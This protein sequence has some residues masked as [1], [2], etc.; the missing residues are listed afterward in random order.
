MENHMSP[1]RVIFSTGSLYTLD[2]AYVFDLAAKAGFD[3]IEVMC[4]DRFSSRDPDYLRGAS[5]R[6]GLPVLVVHTPF[7]FNLIGWLGEGKT[8]VGRIRQTLKIAENLKAESIVVHLPRYV[9]QGML[10]FGNR[11]FPFPW[12]NPTYAIKAWIENEL[13]EIQAQTSVK[14]GIENMPLWKL[15]RFNV[16]FS[17]WNEVE[18]WSRVHDYLTLDTTHW[19]TKGV[20]PI[21]AYNAA[22]GRVCNIH[23]SN[24]EKGQEHRLPQKGEL[25]LAA[26]L[27]RLTETHYEGTVSVEVA[28]DA[29]E[30]YSANS[31]RKN[32]KTTLAFCREHL[33][34]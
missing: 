11:R 10:N 23:L 7:T 15:G 16:D 22:M 2:V 28:L 12:T 8:Q 19:A 21:E 31:L 24:Y 26:F 18:T 9:G 34:Q 29:L 5:K 20:N 14:I 25:D 3:G 6:S 4:D 30:F 27:H 1:A 32:L 13:P 33:G 17:Y